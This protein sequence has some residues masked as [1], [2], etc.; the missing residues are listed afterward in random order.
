MKNLKYITL[1]LIAVVGLT[2]LTS[3]EDED[4]NRLPELEAG[5]LVVFVDFPEFNAGADPSTASFNELVEDANGNVASYNLQVVGDFDGATE[6]TLN[7]AS[8]TT[9]PFDVSFTAADMASLFGV[10]VSDFQE[11]D[12]FTFLGTAVTVDGVTYDYVETSFTSGDPDTGEPGTWNGA[13]ST[14]PVLTSDG[15]KQAFIYEVE[16]SDPEE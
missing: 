7:F 11:G 8:T 5:G 3:C 12:S 1:A 4:K 6:D 15:I 9:F 2:T 16:F 13:N 10:S 14:N